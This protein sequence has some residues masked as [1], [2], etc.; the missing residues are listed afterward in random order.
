MSESRY[1]AIMVFPDNAVTYQ[2]Y[3]TIRNG[4]FSTSLPA[5]AVIERRLDGRLE[6]PE[7]DDSSSGVG[8]AT[9]SLI[10]MLVGVLGGPLGLLLGMGMGAM[11]GLIVDV[12]REDDAE[13]A[14]TFMGRL[15][16]PGRNALIA[17]TR[18]SDP[19]PLDTAV[20]GLGGTIT[21]RPYDE[22]LAELE[23]QEDAV[24]EAARAARKVMREQKHAEH[25]ADRE[26][27]LADLRARF[28]R[29]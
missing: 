16:P 20:A 26:Q 13:D 5:V 18:E 6:I 2:A 19:D 24:E 12:T 4:L 29:T 15:V 21:R 10:G 3:S 23:A 25:K 1:M 7:E 8:T 11:G 27:R 14:I 28:S 17:E 22:V 9:G